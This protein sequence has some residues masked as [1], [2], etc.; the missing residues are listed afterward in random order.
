MGNHQ[1]LNTRKWE[2]LH[3]HLEKHGSHTQYPHEILVRWVSV[4]RQERG[5]KALDIGFGSGRNLEF[6]EKTGYEP[7]GV[8]VSETAIRHARK[9]SSNFHLSIFKPPHLD[10]P[11]D[12]FSLIIS[13]QAFYYNL[14]LEQVV[15]ET[16]RVMENGGY[17]YV[18]FYGK[19]HWWV[20]E[21]SSRIAGDSVIEWTDTHPA[22]T[23]RGLRLRY[24][25]TKTQYMALFRDFKNVEINKYTYDLFGHHYEYVFVIA[26]K[27]EDSV[28]DGSEAS[29]DQVAEFYK[30][31]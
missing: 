2:R 25:E 20:K 26:Q 23:E 18:S 27:L 7:F 29:V 10:F 15:A 19:N 11:D 3:Q 28:P 30:G 22:P 1:G 12:F 5:G 8:E 14:D 16:H 13:L 4:N 31:L 9:I 21:H 6:L 24:F 17:L